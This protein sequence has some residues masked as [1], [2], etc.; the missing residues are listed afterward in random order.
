MSAKQIIPIGSVER[1][2]AFVTGDD[3]TGTTVE[4]SVT[5]PTEPYDWQPATWVKTR[6]SG[7]TARTTDPV[8]IV[9]AGTITVAP[10]E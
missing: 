7:G 2:G 3:Y 9:A 6:P 5:P 1:V 10:K 8:I 4:I